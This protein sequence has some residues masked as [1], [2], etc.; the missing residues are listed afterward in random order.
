MNCPRC[1]ALLPAGGPCPACAPLASI[2][3]KIR[4]R[5]FIGNPVG[6]WTAFGWWA[7]LALGVVLGVGVLVQAILWPA[8]LRP[9]SV[10]VALY[11]VAVAAFAGAVL[12]S[13]VALLYKSLIRPV[14][15]ALLSSE[16]F[17]REYGAMEDQQRPP[18]R[19]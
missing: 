18:G 16:L 11:V 8:W 10:W 7:G 17:E 1:G 14:I 3:G 4:R 13:V 9:D 5:R 2:E 15:L 19:G 6:R 12:G